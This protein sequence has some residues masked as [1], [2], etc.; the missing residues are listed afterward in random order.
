M[1]KQLAQKILIITIALLFLVPAVMAEDAIDWY[2]RGENSATIGKYEDAITYYDH[3]IAMD[4]KYASALS[5]KAYS[6]NQ[7]GNYTG[8]LDFSQRALAV[9][10]D[11]RALNARA[12][13]LFKLQRYDEAVAAYDTLFKV[14]TNLPEPY[15]NQGIAYEQIN[16]SEKAIV[17]FDSCARL[18]PS[19]IFPWF[20]KGKALLSLGK[21]EEALDAFNRCTQIT[22]SDAEVWNYKGVAF[23]QTGKYQ[24]AVNCF[25]SALSIDPTYSEAKKNMDLAMNRAQV[26]QVSGS[27][28]PTTKPVGVTTSVEPLPV[29]TGTDLE[30]TVPATTAITTAIPEQ[31]DAV[32]QTKTTYSP[33]PAWVIIAGLI[34]AIMVLG[35]QKR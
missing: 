30:P 24:D 20:R 31:T 5:G 17:A 12:N 22:I 16:E 34:I 25:K 8:A 28:L 32:P 18:D 15:C 7:I 27:P 9:R 1:H 3:A 23:L 10:Q 11:N 26:Y 2:M 29:V 6:L 35:P 4:Q 14:Q 21:P 19:D 13:A 33:L